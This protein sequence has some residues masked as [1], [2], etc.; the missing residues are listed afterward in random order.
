M[1]MVTADLFLKNAEKLKNREKIKIYVHELDAE[2]EFEPMD[3]SRFLDLI[4]G[5]GKD[6]DAETI[7]YSCKE[8]RDDSLIEALGCKADPVEVVGKVLSGSAIFLIASTIATKSG[9]S[10]DDDDKVIRVIG[11][12]IKNS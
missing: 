9:Y 8:L 6:R 12:D 3:R 5:S 7:Y 10:W 1:G 11:E 2:I 4:V